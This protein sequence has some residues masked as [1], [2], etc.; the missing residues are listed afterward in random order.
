MLYHQFEN[1]MRG[2]LSD[3][4][5]VV[6]FLQRH[7]E[8]KQ[9]EELSWSELLDAAWTGAKHG[10]TTLAPERF[11]RAARTLGKLVGST[12]IQDWATQGIDEE[13]AARERDPWYRPDPR[14]MESEWGRSMYEGFSNFTAALPMMVPGAA[15]APFTGGASLGA[16][17]VGGAAS[18][19]TLAGLSEYDS[20]IDE[21]YAQMS[22][23]DPS[24]TREVVE[25]DKFWGA[26]ISGLAE[27]GTS[28]ASDLIGGK[29]AGVVGKPAAKAANSVVTKL[30]KN[31]TSHMAVELGEE[32]ATAYAQDWAREVWGMNHQGR[33]EA[34][35]NIIGPTL[36]AGGLGGVQNTAIKVG[37]EAMQPPSVDE[38][39]GGFIQQVDDAKRRQ[40]LTGAGYDFMQKLVERGASDA[41][42]AFNAALV[43][44]SLAKRWSAVTG[45]HSDTWYSNV[46]TLQQQG[47]DAGMTD[48]S[49]LAVAIADPSQTFDS[50]VEQ[51]TNFLVK[52]LPAEQR[53]AITELYSDTDEAFN[54]PQ[55]AEDLKAFMKGENSDMTLD[56]PT[57]TSFE[58]MQETLF[59][60]IQSVNDQSAL[61]VSRD[62]LSVL[63]K[64]IDKGIRA[65][66][67]AI[68]AVTRDPS[69]MESAIKSIDDIEKVS[70]EGISKLG[71]DAAKSIKV[72]LLNIG[73]PEDAKSAFDLFGKALSPMMEKLEKRGV[74]SDSTV[75]S[76]A[77]K[78]V[79]REGINVESFAKQAEGTQD[80]PVQT[81]KNKLSLMAA[82]QVMKDKAAL[83]LSTKTVE[84]MTQARLMADTVNN[85][86]NYW[87][88]EGT[89]LGRAMRLRRLSKSDA[90][91]AEKL[92]STFAS[93][94]GNNTAETLLTA[95][96]NSTNDAELRTAME[97]SWG[98]KTQ[99]A[100]V[101]YVTSGM[102]FGPA[103]HIVN[104]LSNSIQITNE[105]FTRAYAERLGGKVPGGI[106]RGETMAM[107]HGIWEGLRNVKNTWKA[108]RAGFESGVV[109]TARAALDAQGMWENSPDGSILMDTGQ[110]K[111][112]ISGENAAAAI[113]AVK[114]KL[115]MSSH[116]GR[117]SGGLS[118][119]V[120]YLGR[121]LNLPFD[122]LLHSD[123][124]FK[125]VA[126]GMELN[127]Q[128]WRASNGDAD[129]ANTLFKNPPKALRD[130]A[131]AFAKRVTFQDD[132]G[133]VGTHIDAIR[134]ELP[135]AR[136]MLP[137][138]KTPVNIYKEGARMTP[139][140][141]KVFKDIRQELNSDDPATRQLSEAKLMVG[142]MIWTSAVGLAAAGYI[143][144]PGPEEPD[145]QKKLLASGWRPN[146]VKIGEDYYQIDRLDPLAFLFNTAGFVVE[147]KDHIEAEDLETAFGMGIGQSLRM[148]TDRTYMESFQDVMNLITNFERHKDTLQR[149][150][151][152]MLVPASALFRTATRNTDELQREV[153]GFIS[154]IYAGIP[155]A[156]EA[157]PVKRDFLGQPVESLKFAG[158]N[159]LSP[160][161]VGIKN[162]DK[163]YQEVARLQQAGHT[164][165]PVPSR[166]ITRN[167]SRHK[168]NG[169]EY[170]R[171]LDLYGNGVKIEGRTAKQ[172]LDRLLASPRY[173]RMFDEQKAEAIK[174]TLSTYGSKARDS[175]VGK[176]E[177]IRRAL[178]L[179]TQGISYL[180][181]M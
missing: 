156:S 82:M 27:G 36:V 55:L 94:G 170:S 99:D 115:G 147:V 73:S 24:V 119:A 65:K 87:E 34:I 120:E 141:N 71:R 136:L 117:I 51:G 100:I 172:A 159:W 11:Y 67:R 110:M 146:A 66:E 19:G 163:V 59:D 161:Q 61:K 52:N 131:Q 8:E 171:F 107:M 58:S 35:K 102:L 175:L 166:V 15:L 104:T 144:G 44:D 70:E 121:V 75:S 125:S 16:A 97:A 129:A 111:R 69:L 92:R 89:N 32:A 45:E 180:L 78:A 165:A 150:F 176:D 142:T 1:E 62:S 81:V 130:K 162:K 22:A 40:A 124:V 63:N 46:A 114:G 2:Q 109:G 57:R 134:N 103:T 126:Y 68:P 64:A 28:I 33:W 98:R 169:D 151:G 31:V 50:V 25:S 91:Y 181:G 12:G 47:V 30:I 137:F 112:A 174:A 42:H 6:P 123:Q 43:A 72:D 108:H 179:K 3:D 86:L 140:L 48:L 133:S 148:L 152:G 132:L 154:S 49:A 145:A 83:A 138:L 122:L 13:L 39:A 167:G 116:H 168:M 93:L 10:I 17:F 9:Q 54:T 153:D 56:E 160:F 155:G 157:L 76:L 37:Q 60:S 20:F 149:R 158:N 38:A 21:A 128:C 26:V 41:E 4:R 177:N 18:G 7:E 95:I 101:E 106:V 143:T 173:A 77:M 96:M 84:D 88:S 90:L 118:T 127:A 85:M 178:N 105:L 80:S 29:L 53:Q 23:V 135:L 14:W 5:A 79:A 164:A 74:L 113:N 139:G